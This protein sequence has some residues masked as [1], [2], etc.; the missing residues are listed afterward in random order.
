MAVD[1]TPEHQLLFMIL[2]FEALA[3]PLADAL[4]HEWI[5]TGHLAGSLL[6][7]FLAEI[8]HGNWPGRD[9]LDALLESDEERALIASLL[10][11][12]PEL[13]A[14]IRQVI[15]GMTKLRQ[16][17]LE[18]RLRQIELDLANHHADIESDPISL[19]RERSELHRQLSQPI[20]LHAAV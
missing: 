16:R 11:E 20:T 4:P 19:L 6:N 1:I 5:D 18:P 2:H 14:P 3:R 8:A 7:R 15:Q 10:F 12:A 9:Q 13:D 17:A